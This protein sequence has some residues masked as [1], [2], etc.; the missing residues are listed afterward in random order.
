MIFKAK[1]TF[2]GKYKLISIFILSLL[3]INVGIT[4]FTNPGFFLVIVPDYMPYHLFLVYVSGFF[5]I[6]LGF[7][8]LF[9]KTRKYAGIGLVIL[10]IL[11]FPA[12]IFLYQSEEAQSVY[13]I[14]KN[15]AFIRMFFQFPLILL[16]Y[17]HSLSKKYKCLDILCAI[18]FIPTIVYFISLA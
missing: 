6:I 3:Y 14:S 9:K 4:H 2:I 17:W 18:I 12:N 1:N 10:L 8:L 5:E 16:A 11:V 7:L 15:K 13:E